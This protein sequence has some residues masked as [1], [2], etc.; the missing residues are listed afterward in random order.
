MY[1]QCQLIKKTTATFV[2]VQLKNIAIFVGILY[3]K[4]VLKN[5][6]KILK[7]QKSF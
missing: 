7:I 6:D 1:F 2:V 5:K 4:N 3:A